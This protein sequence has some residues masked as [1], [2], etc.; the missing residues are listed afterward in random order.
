V[1]FHDAAR[2]R[3]SEAGASPSGL[4]VKNGSNTR[5]RISAGIPGPL[6]ATS[7]RTLERRS[8]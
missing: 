4:V 5:A 1:A 2:Q 3:Q 6:S 7:M 8:S